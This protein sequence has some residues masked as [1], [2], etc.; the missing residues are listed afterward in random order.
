MYLYIS[1]IKTDFL[2]Q[3]PPNSAIFRED[4]TDARL[5]VPK[6]SINPLFILRIIPRNTV[7]R[8]KMPRLNR[9]SG[10]YQR[11]LV[12]QLISVSEGDP[13]SHSSPLPCLKE[14]GQVLFLPSQEI[15]APHGK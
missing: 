1:H 11:E 10:T 14:P 12:G 5:C 13:M 15:F 3:H 4:A 9:K 7:N 8:L 2:N 6:E